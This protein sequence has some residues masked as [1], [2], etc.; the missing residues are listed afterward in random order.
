MIDRYLVIVEVR[1]EK[2]LVV[3]Y[4]HPQVQ[5]RLNI[6]W[7]KKDGRC[8]ADE[9]LVNILYGSRAPEKWGSFQ[10]SDEI[11][12]DIGPILHI[13]LSNRRKLVDITTFKTASIN[14][15]LPL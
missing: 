15:F 3:F 7:F 13:P 6:N 8:F 2:L 4:E 1:W 14:I 11:A 12:L 10:V 9:G 5:F